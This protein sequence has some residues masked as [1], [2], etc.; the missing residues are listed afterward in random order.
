MSIVQIEY[1]EIIEGKATVDRVVF[2]NN[3][4]NIVKFYVHP[5]GLVVSITHCMGVY[6]PGEVYW[7]RAEHSKNSKY[8]NS[9]KCIDIGVSSEDLRK[10]VPIVDFVKTVL[11]IKQC[12]ELVDTY[13]GKQIEEIL[14]NEDVESLVKIKW[15]GEQN[16]RDLIKQYKNFGNLDLLKQKL[17]K[18]NMTKNALKSIMEHYDNNVN[19]AIA[20]LESNFFNLTKVKG[21]GFKRV[22]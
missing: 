14:V 21:F 18:Y 2:S 10:E 8:P 11:N 9:Y 16:A 13:D 5:P 19:H 7:I 1:P 3:Y 20:E 22:D 17:K 15:I 6:N 12:A 4:F